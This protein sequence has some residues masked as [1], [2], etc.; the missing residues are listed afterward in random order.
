MRQQCSTSKAPVLRA[1]TQYP[2]AARPNADM[3]THSLALPPPA[4]CHAAQRAART[5]TTQRGLNSTQRLCLESL[6]LKIGCGA[7]RSE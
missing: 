4:Q 1:E 5:Q 2:S 3:D 6:A 7:V